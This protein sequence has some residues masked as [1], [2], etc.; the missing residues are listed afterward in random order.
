[1]QRNANLERPVVANVL[2]DIACYLY[3]DTCD[4]KTFTPN[5]FIEA[6][7]TEALNFYIF[8]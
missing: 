2:N 5:S 8:T 4:M 1:V 6:L 7:R 3:A